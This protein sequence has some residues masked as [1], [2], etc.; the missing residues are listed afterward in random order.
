MR[1]TRQILDSLR[2]NGYVVTNGEVS[3]NGKR[4]GGILFGN[5]NGKLSRVQN[6]IRYTVTCDGVTWNID[7]EAGESKPAYKVIRRVKIVN[8][9]AG[10]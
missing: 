2:K 4:I 6:G 9:I 5:P 8:H 10:R 3:K 7:C 1:N